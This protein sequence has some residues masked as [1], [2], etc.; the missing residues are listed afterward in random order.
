MHFGG[1]ASDWGSM[2]SLTS[3]AHQL[4]THPYDD[5]Y[6]LEFPLHA[7]CES[8]IGKERHMTAA[9]NSASITISPTRTAADNVQPWL[10]ESLL[11]PVQAHGAFL[12]MEM[13]VGQNM[14]IYNHFRP[15]TCQRKLPP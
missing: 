2:C 5:P 8:L 9:V 1:P 10:W 6:I 14:L 13:I 4:E 3:T 11:T 15:L 7:I 12:D